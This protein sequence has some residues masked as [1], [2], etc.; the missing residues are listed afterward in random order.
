MIEDQ[1][2]H[3]CVE[4]SMTA[5]EL[6]KKNRGRATAAAVLASNMIRL[7]MLRSVIDAGA[8]AATSGTVLLCLLIA[9][10][11]I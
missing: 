8:A 5:K 6:Q 1:L 11:L 9:K 10:R 3:G 7:A 2:R 4:S